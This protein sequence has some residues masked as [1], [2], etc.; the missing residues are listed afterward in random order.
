MARKVISIIFFGI[1]SLIWVVFVIAGIYFFISDGDYIDLVGFFILGFINASIF[2]GF[3]FAIRKK[4][5][6]IVMLI[7]GIAFIIG[8]AISFLY[9]T[10]MNRD[11][12]AILR[13]GPNPGNEFV[14]GGIMLVFIGVVLLALGFWKKHRSLPK[15]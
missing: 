11:F 12:S 1:A 4:K 14:Y 7:F 3:G 9:G 8:G 15:T 5:V 13:Y 2:V 6:E 10:A